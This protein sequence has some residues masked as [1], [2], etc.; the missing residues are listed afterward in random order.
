MRTIRPIRFRQLRAEHA[1]LRAALAHALDDGGGGP[2][3]AGQ[4]AAGRSSG[5]GGDAGWPT[6]LHAYWQMSGLIGE[7]R[8]YLD[9]AL[10][11]VPGPSRERAWV[12][13]V[14]GR[15]ATFQGD[16][17]EAVADLRESIRL[18]DELGEKLAAARGYLYLNLALT[19]SGEHEQA[20][21]AGLTAR[22]RLAAS[23]DRVGLV[24]LEPQLAQLRQLGGDIDAAL[25]CCQR[26]QAKLADFSPAWRGALDH[27]PAA[28]DRRARPLPAAGSRRRLR[29]RP[30]SRAADLAR[31]RQ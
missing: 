29:H 8:H 30:P 16:L 14:R 1:N 17:A 24:C 25:E 12:L 2:T 28:A 31:P 3:A 22:E 9:E 26:G 13:A 21:V 7:G 23:D 20:E 27:R 18:A 19:Y 15:L 10:R 11:V 4:A 6:R 5:G